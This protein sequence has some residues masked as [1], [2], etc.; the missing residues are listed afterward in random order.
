MVIT[1][2]LV[3]YLEELGRIHLDET[4]EQ[5]VKEDMQNIIAYFDTLNE[6]NT[7][8]VEPVSHSFPIQNVMREDVVT[9]SSD[10]ETLLL[11]APEQSEGCYVVPRTVE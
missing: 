10:R 1:D 3:K 8:D 4:M 11:N 5:K 6:L 7:D 9:P 2:E